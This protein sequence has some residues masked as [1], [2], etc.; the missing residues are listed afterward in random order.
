V[1][2]QEKYN[3]KPGKLLGSL[4]EV[5]INLAD[6]DPLFLK[7]IERYV[8]LG[9]TRGREKRGRGRGIGRGRPRLN[10]LNRA[11]WRAEG[12]AKKIEKFTRYFFF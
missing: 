4:V 7:A 2:D 10:A 9:W 12:K 1:K 11:R 8:S 3:F 6:Q 5:Y